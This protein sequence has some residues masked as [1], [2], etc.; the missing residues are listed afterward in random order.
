MADLSNVNT[1]GH[2]QHRMKPGITHAPQIVCMA[3]EELQ[4]ILVANKDSAEKYKALIEDLT[5]RVAQLE[6]KPDE[7]NVE[8]QDQPSS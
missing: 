3:V 6:A 2:F 1:D 8:T 5:K 7:Q 4:R